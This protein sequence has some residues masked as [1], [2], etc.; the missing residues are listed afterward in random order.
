MMMFGKPNHRGR[1]GD[2]I[3]VY[4]GDDAEENRY[5]YWIMKWQLVP[6][7]SSYAWVNQDVNHEYS[8]TILKTAKAWC[9]L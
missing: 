9:L 3:A 4:V 5:G 1:V 7:K 6:G 2:K 8:K